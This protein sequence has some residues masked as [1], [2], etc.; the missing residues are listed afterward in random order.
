MSSPITFPAIRRAA[1][2]ILAVGLCVVQNAACA[3]TIPVADRAAVA[4]AVM[5]YR[6][7]VLRDPSLF[8]ACALRSVVGA[9]SLQGVIHP[10]LLAMIDN[11]ANCATSSA[12]IVFEALAAADTGFVVTLMVTSDEYMHQERYTVQHRDGRWFV[13]E[14]R[15]SSASHFIPR[16]AVRDQAKPV[17]DKHP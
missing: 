17:S 9:S 8:N 6:S 14:A 1:F 2:A 15:F 5:G 12:P 7:H 11:E 16:R 13:S 10:Q 3:Q 4:E